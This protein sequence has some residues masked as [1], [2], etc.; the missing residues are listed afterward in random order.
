MYSQHFLSKLMLREQVFEM[1]LFLLDHSVETEVMT[2]RGKGVK[3]N[4][5]DKCSDL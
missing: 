5:P 1:S 2:S 3:T 4:F